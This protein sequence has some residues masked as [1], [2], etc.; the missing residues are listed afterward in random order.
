[1][2]RKPPSFEERRTW[3]HGS[4]GGEVDDFCFP[5]A[6]VVGEIITLHYIITIN[7]I[8]QCLFKKSKT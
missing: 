5:G 4:M 2:F 6:H 1:M 8:A 7:A 3:A